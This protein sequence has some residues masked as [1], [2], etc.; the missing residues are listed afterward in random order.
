M[1]I[2]D[3]TGTPRAAIIPIER[4]QHLRDLDLAEKRARALELL[5]QIEAE[6]AAQPNKLTPEEVEELADRFSREMVDDLVRDGKIRF[7][8]TPAS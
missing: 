7:E 5:D 6:Y 1:V 3:A 8:D 2:V 4:Y